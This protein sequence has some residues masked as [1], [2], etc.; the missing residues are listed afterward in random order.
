M[1]MAAP[2][3]IIRWLSSR[4]HFAGPVNAIVTGFRSASLNFDQFDRH[5]SRSVTIAFTGPAKWTREDNH[6]DDSLSAPAM[7]IRLREVLPQRT[8]GGVYGV[9]ASKHLTTAQR[10]T[11]SR[12]RL[13][14]APQR[15]AELRKAVL[16][17]IER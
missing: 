16:D 1:R 2:R 8:M 17:L 3:E 14:C 15:V 6:S 9:G 5:K 10:A 4:V 13:V 11:R 12:S 7:R